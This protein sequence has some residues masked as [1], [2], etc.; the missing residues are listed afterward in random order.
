MLYWQRHYSSVSLEG[1]I[2]AIII[3]TIIITQSVLRQIHSLSQS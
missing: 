3:I 2:I 1:I